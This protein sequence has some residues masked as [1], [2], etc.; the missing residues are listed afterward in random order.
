MENHKD[1]FEK[2]DHNSIILGFLTI[3][4]PMDA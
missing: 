1:F 3:E 4:T 2:Q